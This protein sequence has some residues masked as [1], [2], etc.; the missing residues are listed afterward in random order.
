MFH[1]LNLLRLVHCAALS[2]FPFVL[3]QGFPS[4]YTLIDLL[5]NQPSEILDHLNKIGEAFPDPDQPLLGTSAE[6][7]EESDDSEESLEES[8]EKV[9]VR[10]Q[11]RTSA[12]LIERQR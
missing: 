11:R 6:S 5:Q 1:I 3:S 12:N 10:R 2:Q 8:N 9:Q 4:I 7:D